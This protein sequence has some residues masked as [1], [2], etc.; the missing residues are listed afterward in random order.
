MHLHEAKALIHQREGAWRISATRRKPG[1]KSMR[2]RRAYQHG[3]AC[4]E[5]GG[6]GGERLTKTAKNKRYGVALA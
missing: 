4:G 2:R 3:I 6:E 1:G 5:G